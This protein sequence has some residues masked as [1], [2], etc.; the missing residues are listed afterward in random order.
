MDLSIIH[1]KSENP[2]NIV[3]F[4]HGNGLLLFTQLDPSKKF[5]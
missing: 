3:N 5:A 2:T 4:Q 1:P